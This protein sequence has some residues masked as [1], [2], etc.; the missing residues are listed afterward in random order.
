[1]E[2][3]DTQLITTYDDQLIPPQL[4]LD[5]HHPAN[6]EY[7]KNIKHIE[8]AVVSAQSKL[9]RTHVHMVKARLHGE[10]V[11]AIAE[12]YNV[13][14]QT[15]S[16]AVNKPNAKKLAALLSHHQLAIE[17]PTNAQRANMLWRI[18]KDTEQNQPRTAIT[19]VDTLNK[20]TLAAYEQKANNQSPT[21]NIQINQQNLPKTALDD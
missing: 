15:V 1:M 17:G 12:R 11:I 7:L 4:L 14:P 16:A 3:T 10:S 18:A 20:M 21:I 9:K 2:T 19:A 6:D 13:T 8:R 5:E